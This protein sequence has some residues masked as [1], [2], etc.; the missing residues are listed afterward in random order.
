MQDLILTCDKL[1]RV[2]GGDVSCHAA[3]EDNY[4]LLGVL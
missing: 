3:T 4:N 2:E 1:P